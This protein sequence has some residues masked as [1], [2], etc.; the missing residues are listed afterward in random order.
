M[1]SNM[2][3]A[4]S[5]ACTARPR[6]QGTGQINVKQ[7]IV[8]GQRGRVLPTALQSRWGSWEVRRDS[9]DGGEWGGVRGEPE[10]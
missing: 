6:P 1:I 8:E 7:G 9:W 3:P 10:Q 2:V 5:Q 4:Q